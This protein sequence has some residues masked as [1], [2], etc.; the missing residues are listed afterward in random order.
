MIHVYK[1]V[2]D[3]AHAMQLVLHMNSHKGKSWKQLPL[4]HLL[5]RC[6]EEI[7]ELEDAIELDDLTQVMQECADVANFA[8]FMFNKAM[9]LKDARELKESIK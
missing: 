9:L 1:E 6:C 7:K 2:L 5:E 8:C 4:Q 3:F